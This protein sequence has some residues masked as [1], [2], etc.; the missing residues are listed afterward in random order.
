MILRCF[1]S[2]G[3]WIL[4]GVLTFPLAGCFLYAPEVVKAFDGKYTAAE[5][6]KIIT[7]YCQSCHNH[8]DFDPLTH[9][10]AMKKT[11]K[12]KA[13]SNATECRTCHYVKTQFIRN[14]LIRK[15]I[16]PHEV[17]D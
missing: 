8:K 1:K 6:N 17:K 5:N 7:Q 10:E 14:E 9:M 2:V 11:Y 15:T 13:F 3:I 12:K 4:L 16:R